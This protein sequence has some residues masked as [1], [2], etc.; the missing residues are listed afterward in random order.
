MSN[1]PFIPLL[2]NDYN[3]FV[4]ANKFLIKLNANQ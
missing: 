2:E 4:T 1:T 3:I